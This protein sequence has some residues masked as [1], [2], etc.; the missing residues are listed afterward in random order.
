MPVENIP[1]QEVIMAHCNCLLVCTV[2]IV[3]SYLLDGGEYKT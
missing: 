3:Y 2:E 1:F